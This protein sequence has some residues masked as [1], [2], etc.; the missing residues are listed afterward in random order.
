MKKSAVA[1]LGLG[2]MAIVGPAVWWYWLG[3]APAQGPAMQAWPASEPAR[4]APTAIP[5]AA[6]EPGA[7]H[8]LELPTPAAS[9]PLPAT[10][11]DVESLL[12]DLFGRK[13]ALGMFQVDDFARR[14]V[15]TIDNLGRSHAPSRLWP[16]NPAEGRFLTEKQGDVEVIS[17]DNSLRYTPYVLLIETVDLRQVAAAYLKLYPQLQKTYEDLGYPRRHFNDRVV[18]VIDLLIATPDIDAAARVRLPAING[19]MQPQRPWVLYEF[20]DPVLQSLT[21]GQR[22]LLRTGPVNERRLKAK[23]A[24]LRRLLATGA[25]KQ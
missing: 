5:Q 10:A 14:V 22:I 18:E 13:S 1:A 19:P 8:P 16:V 7:R 6:S 17:G 9:A 15:V 2:L 21:A 11:I 25:P 24:E 23:L 12:T 3:Q 4:A 20:E